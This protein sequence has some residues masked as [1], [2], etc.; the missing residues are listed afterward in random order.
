M[1]SEATFNKDHLAF[2]H[3]HS[4]SS[5]QVFEALLKKDPLA[6]DAN[7]NINQSLNAFIKMKYVEKLPGSIVRYKVTALGSAH[8]PTKEQ[9]QAIA[10]SQKKANEI[11]RKKARREQAAKYE[12]LKETVLGYLQEHKNQQY[13][14]Q[15]LFK[16]LELQPS[17]MPSLK[18]ILYKLRDA[19]QIETQYF[20]DSGLYWSI[21]GEELKF[22]VHEK[23][24]YSDYD[25]ENDNEDY[26]SDD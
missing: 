9:L 19:E 8:F 4:G 23:D 21:V 5:V 24:I 26:Y 3:R 16:V 6:T 17:D 14:I 7:F 11:A 2:F 22:S 1:S 10:E 20:K 25:G 18:S 13:T 12:A 15:A